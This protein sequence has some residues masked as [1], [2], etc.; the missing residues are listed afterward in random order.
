MGHFPLLP[1]PQ[2]Q[3]LAVVSL[4]HIF[5][6]CR[7]FLQISASSNS[8]VQTNSPSSHSPWT[9]DTDCNEKS[10]SE[11]SD[12]ESFINNLLQPL[13]P[14]RMTIRFLKTHNINLDPYY[15]IILKVI[16]NFIFL[17]LCEIYSHFLRLLRIKSFAKLSS[18]LYIEIT[19]FCAKCTF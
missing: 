15:L 4:L 19:R 2:D 13:M 18:F 16:F 5:K 8:Q 10:N 7:F 12:N 3:A 14:N 17:S 11:L 9:S 6:I 1:S